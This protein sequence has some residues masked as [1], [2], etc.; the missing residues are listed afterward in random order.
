MAGTRSVSG[1]TGE[2][3]R[4]IDVGWGALRAI[5]AGTREG[6]RLLCLHGW[7]DNAASFLP[8]ARQLPQFH[9]VALDFAGHGRSDHRPEHARYYF[10]DYVFDVDAALDDLGWDSCTLVGHS[11]GTAVAACN[12]CADPQRVERIVMLD[13]LGVVTEPERHAA[14]RLTRSLRSVRHPR[15]HRRV[16]ASLELAARARQVKNPMADDSARLLAERALRETEGGWRWRTD[17]R[18]MWDSPYWYAEPHSDAIL[19][20]LKCPVLVVY[21]P[22]LEHYLDER[23]AE[24]LKRLDDVTAV[25]LEGGHH[26]H[27]DQP[28]ALADAVR[29]FIDQEDLQHD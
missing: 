22:V 20:G 24:R 7:M 21:T 19:Q 9:W 11:L 5:E 26:V 2:Q 12:A 17:P 23:L 28:E 14:E 18:A 25:R 16:F 8:L 4:P 13:G 29:A 6:P 3:D 10:M 15:D 27:M 1:E